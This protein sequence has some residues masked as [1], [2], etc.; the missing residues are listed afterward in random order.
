MQEGLDHGLD[1]FLGRP[2]ITYHGL[3]H[4][5]RAIFVNGQTGFCARQDRRASGLPKHHGAL[6]VFTVKWPLYT[7]DGWL[8]NIDLT[9]KVVKDFQ[10]SMGKRMLGMGPNYAASAV[11][12]RS[13]SIHLHHAESRGCHSRIYA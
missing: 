4:F 10:E 2:S 13:V 7:H 8:K 6:N 9:A 5:Q 12:Y 1:L 11:A 3:F